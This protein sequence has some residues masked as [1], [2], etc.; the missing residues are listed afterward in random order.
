MAIFRQ[1]PW[2]N[3]F[4]K[5]SIFRL[6]ELLVFIPQKGV[7]SFQNILKDIFL[8]YIAT[9]KKFQ[10]WPFL[11]QNDGLTPSEK[12]QFFDFLN[13]LFLQPRKAFFFRFGMSQTTFS[14][15][16]LRQKKKL[17]K[18]PFLDQNH[19]LTILEKCQFFDF[20]NFLFLQPRKVF[21]RSRILQHTFSQSILRKKKKLEKRSFWTKTMG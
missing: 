10:K 13:L 18:W 21:F 4:G 9:K 11:D 8:A 6:F 19:G 5:K 3:H 12:S 2:V 7:F 16:I 17:E 20:F 14:W 1:K 15:S